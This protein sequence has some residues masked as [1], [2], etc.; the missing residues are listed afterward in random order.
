MGTVWVVG[1]LNADVTVE[2][3]RF[4]LP[5]ET[6]AGISTAESFGGKGGNQAV[7][8]ARL[9]A[10]PRMVGAV[11]GDG[12]G[13][14]YARALRREGVRAG[15]VA[16][17]RGERTGF[18]LIEACG[19]ENRITVVPGANGRLTPS[20]A[21]PALRGISRG[22][23]LLLQLEIPLETV[24]WALRLARSAG[25]TTVLD[26][27]PA[28]PLP[29]ETLSL[30]DYLT[31]NETEA[32]TLSGADSPAAGAD[33]LAH[34]RAL[35]AMGCAAVVQKAGSRGAF[36][37]DGSG[38][39][40]SPAFPVEVADTVGAGDTFNAGFAFALSIGASPAEALRWGC[41]AGSLSA[42]RAGAQAAMPSRREVEALLRR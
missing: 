11:G 36:L 7:A 24:E 29:A 26:P 40:F 16:R 15:G 2:C 8:L 19:G 32:A 30:V 38:E 18:A 27:A 1:S 5:G 33:P 23:I 28:R 37:L 9:G 3:A 35:R 12:Y 6:V 22:D 39:S 4:P 25:A 14:A 20:L 13:R 41:A 31:P 21:A 10:S 34:A 17:L 42:R